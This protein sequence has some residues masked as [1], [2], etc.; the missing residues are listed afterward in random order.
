M[1]DASDYYVGAVL[2]QIGDD[3]QW[4]PV[5]FFL[6]RLNSAQ[7]NYSATNRELLAVVMALRRWR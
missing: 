6:K 5:E 2:E 3:Q 1:C 4:H 7:Q